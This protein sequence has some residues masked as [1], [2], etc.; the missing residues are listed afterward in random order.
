MGLEP[1]NTAIIDTLAEVYFQ[2]GENDQAI[3]L[4]QKCLSLEPDARHH[5]ENLARFK[6]AAKSPSTRPTGWPRRS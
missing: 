4:V 1:D 3:K 5:Q 6:A 2:R